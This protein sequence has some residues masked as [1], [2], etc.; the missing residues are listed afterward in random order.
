MAISIRMPALSPTMT[1]G[2]LVR[3]L[4]KEGD[5]VRPGDV[6]AEIE[7]DKATMEVE[8]ADEGTV[9]QLVVPAGAQGI[10]VNEVIAL[11]AGEGETVPTAPTPRPV[12]A[13]V[14][15]PAVLP[16]PATVPAA[17]GASGAATPLA[18]RMAAQA[19]LDLASVAGSGPH[20]KITKAD[21][22][23]ALVPGGRG[24]GAG[25]TGGRLFVSP[26][27]RRLASEAGIDLGS[28][29]GSGPGG[30]IVR[31]DVEAARSVPR[32]LAPAAP[33]AAPAARPAAP[34]P[35][36]PLP[37]TPEFEL[38]PLTGMRKVIARRLTEA[39]QSIPHIYLTIDC[40]M[41]E[42]MRVRQELNGRAP[43]GIKLSVNDFIIKAMALA[44]RKVPDANASWT[45]EGIRRYGRVDVSVAVAIDNGLITPIVFGADGKGL[46][47]ISAE[48]KDLAAR[49]RTGKLKLEEFQGGTVSLS[50]LGMFGIKHFE[51][52]I[53]PPQS[54]ILAVG[55]SERRAV[56]K[57]GQ[58]AVATVMTCT[59]SCD[60]RVVDGVLGAQFLAAFKGYIEFPAA[61][62]L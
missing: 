59:L 16:V 42:L 3:W 52:I 60:H 9:A 23:H 12:P 5:R 35:A 27:A 2:N 22:E 10:K 33:A 24:N 13:P 55:A 11:L 21:V 19:G 47:A 26:L 28:V 34:S 18:A 6:I 15:T 57:A 8:A 49:A 32:V 51:A 25:R 41:D 48:M 1:E 36:A 31:A 45:E 61:M 38:I 44:L 54:S 20:G 46:A 7:T 40:E 50:N 14:V 4:V 58:L 43:E 62:L 39:K 56:V 37:G 17:T 29:S 53:N 30:R